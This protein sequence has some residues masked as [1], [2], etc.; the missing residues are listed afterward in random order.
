MRINKIISIN[1]ATNKLVFETDEDIVAK[2]EI[3]IYVA[4]LS[5]HYKLVLHGKTIQLEVRDKQNKTLQLLANSGF[6]QVHDQFL[7][8]PFFIVKFNTDKKNVEMQNH[9]IVPYSSDYENNIN[10]FLN[11]TTLINY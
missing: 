8:N 10:Q 11:S 9:S 2:S 6:I 7:I 4:Q 5:P 3:A 1:P